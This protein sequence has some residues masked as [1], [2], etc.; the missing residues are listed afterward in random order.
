MMRTMP[1]RVFEDSVIKI[2]LAE[3]LDLEAMIEALIAM[4]YQR[5]PQTEEPGDFSVRGGI[6]DI[7]SPLHHN[8]IRLE[9][10]DDMV[11]SVRHFDPASQRSLGEVEEATVIRTRQVAPSVLRDKRLIE[12]V[13]I[14][15]A[16]IGMV[17][18]E[19]GELT[20]TLETGLLFPGVELITPYIHEE[21]LIDDLQLHARERRSPG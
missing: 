13:A 11:T 18:K 1:R 4:G 15:C 3:R 19:A 21:G 8:P 12:R 14:R 7:F 20:E 2:A 6:I 16:E 17:R 10:E 5:L 9:L